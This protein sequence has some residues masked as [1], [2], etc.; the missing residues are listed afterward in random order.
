MSWSLVVGGED[1]STAVRAN[2]RFTEVAS[3]STGSATFT[4]AGAH[5]ACKPG[6]LVTL[7]RNGS[8]L[9]AGLVTSATPQTDSSGNTVATMV[10]AAPLAAQ[11]AQAVSY[12]VTTPVDVASVAT[13]LV[14]LLTYPL[15]FSGSLVGISAGSLVF[16]SVDD[17]LSVLALIAGK[18]WRVQNGT[19]LFVDALSGMAS[20]PTTLTRTPA[21]CAAVAVGGGLDLSTA[22]PLR[23]SYASPTVAAGPVFQANYPEIA[24]RSTLDEVGN[25]L[26]ERYGSSSFTATATLPAGTQVRAGDW[27][28]DQAQAAAVVASVT[29]L[30]TGG[31][32]APTLQLGF[33]ALPSS[34]QTSIVAHEQAMQH[35]STRVG[36]DGLID[37][38][39]ATSSGLQVT[40]AGGDVELGGVLYSL[41]QAILTLPDNSFS[42]INATQTNYTSQQSIDGGTPGVSLP[43]YRVTTQGGNV[44]AIVPVSPSASVSGDNIIS[45]SIAN[46]HVTPMAVSGSNILPARYSTDLNNN[47][48]AVAQA[49]ASAL[50]GRNALS[51]DS[52][53]NGD[54]LTWDT[55]SAVDAV[56]D[57]PAFQQSLKIAASATITVRF[58]HLG[59]VSGANGIPI[60]LFT[61]SSASGSGNQLSSGSVSGSS[62]PA[63]QV[64]GNRYTQ[65]FTNVNG[66]VKS[67]TTPS[68]TVAPSVSTPL[69]LTLTSLTTPSDVNGSTGVTVTLT[70]PGGTV[71]QTWAN[72]TGPGPKTYTF[73]T[74]GF[75]GGVWTWKIQGVITADN[76]IAAET[77]TD[78]WSG[79][80]SYY[81]PG[82]AGG[83][84][85]I[86]AAD[87]VTQRTAVADAD[88]KFTNQ[89]YTEFDFQITN[90]APSALTFTLG[91][92]C[93][94]L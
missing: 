47:V 75:A 69:T 7:T 2:A 78:T 1:V 81:I 52:L 88:V 39:S 68:T 61:G 28:V 26:V 45:G 66:V 85:Y 58:R 73:S 63:I 31:D 12:A 65:Y 89:S 87:G 86:L 41:P 67:Y 70:D 25:A 27:V 44:T 94:G 84:V 4:L 38:A 36:A 90:S 22:Q 15:P 14:A 59:F 32:W 34:V 54:T 64:H 43:L 8:E 71:R 77:Y 37:G 91:F 23:A 51:T 74:S 56:N 16:H 13:A 83:A 60:V 17:A 33:P 82:V 49:W 9:W 46:R 80:Q 29:Y 53:A 48:Y 35:P 11:T 92:D 21:I 30:L 76:Q 50:L 93:S 55:G 24:G 3:S 19:V 10:T 5:P 42:Q 79:S 6:A 40:I 62:S 18:S 57:P 72:Q 20:I